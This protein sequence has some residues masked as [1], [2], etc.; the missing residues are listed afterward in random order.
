MTTHPPVTI[1]VIFAVML[2]TPCC[3]VYMLTRVVIKPATEFNVMGLYD[4]V[5]WQFS[6]EHALCSQKNPVD[7]PN[8]I[9][10]PAEPEPKTSDNTN[11]A[12]GAREPQKPN[13][14]NGV[15]YCMCY[16]ILVMLIGVL[17]RL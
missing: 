3:A 4:V 11:A 8:I 12:E 1:A 6:V 16:I 7:K 2:H 13:I 14:G 17:K 9:F 10:S 15:N 5:S